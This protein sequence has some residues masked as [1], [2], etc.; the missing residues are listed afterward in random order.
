MDW[1]LYPICFLTA[2]LAWYLTVSKEQHIEGLSDERECLW[3][4][5]YNRMRCH[6]R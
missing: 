2:F 6:A 3:D 4:P 1:M 5:V